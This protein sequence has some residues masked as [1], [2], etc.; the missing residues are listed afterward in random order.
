MIILVLFAFLGGIVTILSPCILPVLPIVLSG[1]LSGGKE[2]PLGVMTGF[3]GGFTFFTLSLTAVVNAT[4][5]SADTMR[6]ISILIVFG[7]GLTL[8][9]PKLQAFSERMFSRLAS[10][11]TPKAPKGETL[12]RTPDFI[13]GVLIGLSLGLV[14]TP[15]VGPIL[16]SV[17]ALAAT[18]TVTAG[19]VI[20]TVSYATGT[21]IPLLAIT[22]GGRTFLTNHPSLVRRSASV[23]KVFGVLMIVTA[24]AIATNQDRKF[25]TYVL[26]TFPA[27][28]TGLTKI[29]DNAVVQRELENLQKSGGSLKSG[30]DIPN[31]FASSAPELIPGGQW[32]NSEPLTIAGLRG[33]VVL[34][35]FW[36]YTCIN[37]IRT[38]PYIE[39]WHEKYADKG[40]VVIG[41]HTPE[42]AFEKNPENV[43][44][45]IKDFGLTYPVMQDND[46]ATWNAYNNR[47]WPAKY[48]IDKNGK[49]RWTHFGEGAYDESE[50]RIRTLLRESGAT[51]DTEVENPT[52]AIRANTP[53]LYLGYG[54][55]ENLASPEPLVRDTTSPYSAPDP[56]PTHFFAYAGTW[57]VGEERAMPQEGGSLL[58]HFDA[59][60]VYLVM[61]PKTEGINGSMRVFL[62]GQPVSDADAGED[63]NDGT[64]TVT[65][66]RLYKL[67]KLQTPGQHILKL[68]FLDDNLELYAFTFG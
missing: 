6:I 46:Y 37:C 10:R 57:T 38:L 51:I 52:Y 12:N 59:A 56:V 29:E 15:C 60:E 1:S 53:E 25:Q 22:Y 28:G 45:A 3:I 41:V 17:I 47:Y 24:I 31:P 11:V 34:V 50:E 63:T 8:L 58:L 61:R 26:D 44:A 43:A 42:F 4:G 7:F 13:A 39:A 67:I 23:Q 33:K 19:A 16:A 30:L 5:I 64:V 2:K 36:T 32:F 48:F 55:I 62:D 20:L 66:D 49:I 68:D 40:L 14:W 35:D 18:S 54:R 21:V 27:Y 9:F 65:T